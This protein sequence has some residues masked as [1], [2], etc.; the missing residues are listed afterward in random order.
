MAFRRNW[1]VQSLVKDVDPRLILLLNIVSIPTLMKEMEQMVSCLITKDKGNRTSE[2]EIRSGSEGPS[3]SERVKMVT[4]ISRLTTAQMVLRTRHTLFLLENHPLLRLVDQLFV[5][6]GVQGTVSTSSN[7]PS[8]YHID[9]QVPVDTLEGDPLVNSLM[10][11][12]ADSPILEGVKSPVSLPGVQ[13]HTIEL[14]VLFCLKQVAH[15]SIVC[16]L[17]TFWVSIQCV[18]IICEQSEQTE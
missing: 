10:S 12:R 1:F 16:L 13:P 6:F 8:L 15:C 7:S 4:Q 18:L 5:T 14:V 9:L 17:A 2:E 3:V 11:D